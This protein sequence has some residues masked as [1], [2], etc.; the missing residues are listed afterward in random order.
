[1]NRDLDYLANE[2]R[3]I[4]YKISK[5]KGVKKSVLHNILLKKLI[6]FENI[7]SDIIRQQEMDKAIDDIIKSKLKDEDETDQDDEDEDR[8]DEDDT[9]NNEDENDEDKDAYE[10]IMENHSKI[11]K[12]ESFVKY[13]DAIKK[14]WG[15]NR[16]MDRINSERDFRTNPK[17]DKEIDKPYAGG[18]TDSDDYDEQKHRHIA[19]QHKLTKQQ[20]KRREDYPR[21]RSISRSKPHLKPNSKSRYRSRPRDR[22]QDINQNRDRDRFRSQ[23]GRQ[24]NRRY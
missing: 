21:I 23:H 20:A 24:P 6:R 7:K 15:N 3:D 2:I 10:R 19:R 18:D 13:K 22:D 5:S 14:D 17:R 11:K 4:E 12:E 8:N 16:L 1:M 9:D